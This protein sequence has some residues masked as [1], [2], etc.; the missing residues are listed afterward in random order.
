M[1]GSTQATGRSE[2]LGSYESETAGHPARAADIVKCRR[3]P[4]ANLAPFWRVISSF[5]VFGVTIRPPV[6]QAASFEISRSNESCID[7]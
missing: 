7:T 2:H 4:R 5:I 1:N 6:I 3:I